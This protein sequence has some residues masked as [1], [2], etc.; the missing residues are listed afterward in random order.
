MA[1]TLL[2]LPTVETVKG[3]KQRNGLRHSMKSLL[4]FRINLWTLSHNQRHADVSLSH[5]N[6][7]YAMEVGFQR[8]E[9]DEKND[10]SVLFSKFDRHE[11]TVSNL[12]VRLSPDQA[13]S[14]RDKLN[15]MD[16]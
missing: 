1:T 3:A 7:E 9:G 4:E 16:L 15:E 2:P 6:V 12:N 10:V 11:D 5:P 8:T 13:R 14:L